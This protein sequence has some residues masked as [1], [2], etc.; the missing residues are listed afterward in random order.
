MTAM[1]NAPLA[2]KLQ[3]VAKAEQA[4]NRLGFEGVDWS[5]SIALEHTRMVEDGLGKLTTVAYPYRVDFSLEGA[6]IQIDLLR[7]L[8]IAYPQF[9]L[10]ELDEL[11]K[12]MSVHLFKTFGPDH[13]TYTVEQVVGKRFWQ[14]VERTVIETVD[15]ILAYPDIKNKELW[16]DDTEYV[17]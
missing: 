13:L 12:Q 4:A 17:E 1:N 5:L 15:E 9:G 11:M 16:D 2:E 14:S 10:K 7:W 3:L 6:R 8:H